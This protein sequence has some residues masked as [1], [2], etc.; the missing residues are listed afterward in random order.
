MADSRRQ[1]S[2]DEPAPSHAERALG[3]ESPGPAAQPRG[4]SECGSPRLTLVSDGDVVAIYRCPGCG[5]L[6]APV[7]ER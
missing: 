4:C 1:Y 5:H 7:K 6:S 2:I 3:A